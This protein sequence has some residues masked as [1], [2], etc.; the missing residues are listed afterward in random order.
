M[1]ILILHPRGDDIL[2]EPSNYQE[3]FNELAGCADVKFAGKGFPLYRENETIDQTVKR[4]YGDKPPDWVI[5]RDFNLHNKKPTP[6]NYKI[7]LFVSD[8]HAKWHYGVNIPI[9]HIRM[10]N[11]AGYDAVFLR[12]LY[13]R[14]FNVPNDIYLKEL[15]CKTIFVPW[16]VNVDLYS[17]ARERNPNRFQDRMNDIAFLGAVSNFYPL[18][19]IMW[20]ELDKF[21]K[22]NNYSLIKRKPPKG[23]IYDLKMSR[24]M[25]EHYVGWRYVELLVNTKIFPFDC[26]IYGYPI[27]KFF[28]GM[29]AGCLV[30]SVKPLTAEELGFEDGKTYVEINDNNWK[31]KI[32]YYLE[33]IDEA[34]KIASRGSLLVERFHNHRSRAYY[35]VKTLERT[36]T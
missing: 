21:A 33:N 31:D 30:M 1:K 22:E 23:N 18:R 32:K 14:D 7:G 24:L 27:K 36:F 19:K 5:D 20:G 28:E 34:A 29:A 11:E 35:F 13:I 10:I 2:A 17:Q 15:N 6:R 26:S 8:L 3:F 4:M 25:N 9:E 12:S 16:S